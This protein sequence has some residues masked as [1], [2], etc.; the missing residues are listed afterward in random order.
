M[1]CLKVWGRGPCGLFL[2]VGN[3][4]GKNLGIGEFYHVSAC[5]F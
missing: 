2:R 4:N 3:E 5:Y 1:I